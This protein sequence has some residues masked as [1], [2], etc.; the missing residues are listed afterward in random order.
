MI[1]VIIIMKLMVELS[2]ELL[3]KNGFKIKLT[4]VSWRQVLSARE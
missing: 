2:R 3:I 4:S 1:I